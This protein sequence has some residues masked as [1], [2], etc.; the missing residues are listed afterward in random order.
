M[1]SADF[2]APLDDEHAQGSTIPAEAAQSATQHA[3][4]ASQQVDDDGPLPQ[5]PA[6][7]THDALQASKVHKFKY[8]SGPKPKDLH[9]ILLTHFVLDA[10]TEITQPGVGW[11]G[12]P[13]SLAYGPPCVA[14]RCAAAKILNEEVSSDS[15]NDEES[16]PTAGLTRQERKA[17]DRE[18]PWR[19]LMSDYPS[20]I[21]SLYVQANKKEYDSWMSWQ[22]IRA[23]TPTEA[24]HVRSDP[25]LRRRIMPSRNAYRDKNRGAGPSV[26]A[27]CRTVIQGCH[28]PDLGLLDRSSPTPTRLAEYVIYEIA[29]AGYNQRFQNNKKAWKLWAGDV[30][31]AF[32]QGQPQARDMPIFMRPPRDDIQAMAGTFTSEL[33]E[34]VGNLYGLCNAPRTWINHIVTKLLEANFKRH[35]LDHTVYYKLDAHNELMIV[36]L[37]H[38]DDFLATFREDY[39]FKELMDMFTWGQTNL[40][41][42]GDLV[43]KGKEV[44]LKKNHLGEYKIVVTQK[45]FIDELEAGK[46]PRGRLDGDSKLSTTEVKEYRSCAGSLQWLSGTTRPD[47]SATVSLS[48][49]G[50]DNGPQE[51]KT[52]FECIDYLKGSPTDGLTFYGI[53]LNFATA[54]VCYADSS[55][56]NA[57]GGKSQMGVLVLLTGPECQETV[58]RA[59]IMDW[60]SSRSPRVTRSTLAS[61]ANA[62]DEGVDR[63]TFLNVFLSE[64]LCGDTGTKKQRT[65]GVLKQLQVTDCKSLYDGVI[66][67]NPSTEEKRTMISI[68]SIQDFISPQQVHWV[69]SELMHADVLTKHSVTLRSDFLQ[70]MR[71]PKVQ[72]KEETEHRKEKQHQCEFVASHCLSFGA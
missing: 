29:C 28:D 22:S 20:D 67:D 14:F 37:F 11:D 4:E 18:I 66:S 7:R 72:L 62:M 25:V 33:Y 54:V 21:I 40:L 56:A 57:P 50:M 23:L 1:Q 31:T 27:K 36:L 6:K 61:E 19:K 32:L 49:R 59:T 48:N 38:V 17:I 9:S 15:S 64:L 52:L 8:L 39:P 69:P 46:L 30:S 5:L 70:W 44:S 55:W 35:R 71:S 47:I 51:L 53:A 24:A 63:A 43:F 13:P 58:S 3:A 26:K 41:D 10:L 68:R 16:A 45:S 2:D 60:R 42:D 65:T 12:S 34:V